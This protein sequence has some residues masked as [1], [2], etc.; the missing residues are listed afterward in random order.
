MRFLCYISKDF[1]EISEDFIEISEDFIEISEDF[2]EISAVFIIMDLSASSGPFSP[3]SND[4]SIS[5]ATSA[6]TSP[7]S[8][9]S[10]PLQCFS[11]SQSSACQSSSP[12][13]P[14]ESP[15]RKI[16]K[17]KHYSRA[18]LLRRLHKQNSESD[19]NDNSQHCVSN[20]VCVRETEVAGIS[21]DL[22]E[23][24][25]VQF[26]SMDESSSS[27]HS[28]ASQ[29]NS[30]IECSDDTA[31]TVSQS[32]Q[33]SASSDSSE[34]DNVSSDTEDELYDGAN[35][36]VTEAIIKVLQVYVKERWAKASLDSNVKL[37]RSL[38]PSPNL[39]PK[40]GKHMLSK[41]NELSSFQVETE[42]YYCLNCGESKK[43]EEGK[44]LFCND[45]GQ[46]GTFYEFCVEKQL[47]FM[48][49]QRALASAIDE[50]RNRTADQGESST[51]IQ[52]GTAYKKVTNVLN[53]PY[54]IV[55]MCNS[56][57]VNL[58]TSS[59]AGAVGHP[60]CD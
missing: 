52:D 14:N 54:D 45:E 4:S 44:C 24:D 32:S 50:Q 19:E 3:S 47:K 5:P 56:D 49:E 23:I 42:P 57:G 31:S 34:C 60:V 21:R 43:S 17:R 27:E 22:G 16:R 15:P 41:L 46:S 48:F 51:D 58:S 25:R 9:Q 13:S 55:L 33:S 26:N 40:S 29:L 18:T 59:K 30:S 35:I 37:I 28:S 38:P 1:I 53:G 36:R 20:T 7:S 39:F 10:S 12:D 11:D 6:P 2:I 8:G